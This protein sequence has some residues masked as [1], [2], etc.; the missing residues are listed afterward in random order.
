MDY[1]SARLLFIILIDDGKPR[2]RNRCDESIVVFKA[3][4]FE[5]AFR[6]AVE[7]GR[8]NETDYLN[9]DG[10]KVRWA[11][12]AV[13]GLDHVGKTVDGMEVASKLHYRT[14]KQPVPFRRRFHPER[15]KPVQSF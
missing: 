7:I 9:Y 6:R 2:K 5:D 10:Q 14:S 11:F 15:S 4:D 1:Y 8:E 13:D 12:V 3:R